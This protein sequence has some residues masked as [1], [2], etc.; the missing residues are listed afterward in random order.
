MAQEVIA[1]KG[2]LSA[3]LSGS[4]GFDIPSRSNLRRVDLRH[5]SVVSVS[6][7]LPASVA[8]NA[9]SVKIGGRPARS[10]TNWTIEPTECRSAA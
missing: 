10:A 6:L 5:L 7:E 1:L 8:Q 2:V 9:Q 3:R 4:S